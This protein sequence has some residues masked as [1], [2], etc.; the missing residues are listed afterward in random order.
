MLNLINIFEA[1]RSKGLCSSQSDFSERWLGRSG[2]YMAYL[3]SSGTECC[4][5]S[6]ELLAERLQRRAEELL[7]PAPQVCDMPAIKVLRLLHAD[8]VDTIDGA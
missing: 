3:R 1:L 8:L 6:L 4:P 2:S 7:H 5:V